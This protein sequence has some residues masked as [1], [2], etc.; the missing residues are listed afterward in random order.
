MADNLEELTRFLHELTGATG[1]YV[2]KLEHPRVSVDAADNDKAHVQRTQAKVVKF[3]HAT[4]E[5]HKY[6]EGRVLKPDQ[7]V[8]HD[9]FYP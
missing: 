2:G 1:V 5:S 3:V 9:V 6:L 7:G 4:P 8:T